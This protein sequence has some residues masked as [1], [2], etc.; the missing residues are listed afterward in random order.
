MVK[1]PL[2]DYG[3]YKF[4]EVTEVTRT[5]SD[6]S[7]KNYKRDITYYFTQFIPDLPKDEFNTVKVSIDSLLY[8][9]QVSDAVFE[10][11][12]QIDTLAPPN[13]PDLNA[14]SIALGRDY[15]MIYSPYGELVKIEGEK[16]DWLK[17]Y[18]V[19]EGKDRLDS[20]KKII[21]LRGISSEHLKFLTDLQKRIIQPG[22]VRRD[23]IW[24]SPINIQLDE[25]NYFDTSKTRITDYD[26]GYISLET[27]MSDLRPVQE[28][29]RLY[30]IS[31]VA[32]SID[33]TGSGIYGIRVG[34][35]GWIS[36]AWMD[37]KGTLKAQV[38]NEIFTQTIMT[39][40]NW[41]II[42]HYKY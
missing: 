11:N 27:K 8:K 7:Q 12:S 2:H 30:D 23:S 16:L 32:N 22:K 40:A 28:N 41:E 10:W 13:F 39:K 18:I 19:V 26:A 25:V 1:Y 42:S 24:T 14:V 29:I 6:G 15:D 36:K 17:N 35:N 9:F 37:V 4:N 38:K 33:G 21:W 5:Y 34:A 3:V 31:Q 20:L